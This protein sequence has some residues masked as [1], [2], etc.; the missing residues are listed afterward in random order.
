M[1]AMCCINTTNNIEN[2]WKNINL[3]NITFDSYQKIVVENQRDWLVSGESLRTVDVK[4]CNG[5]YA[6]LDIS[7]LS[8][9]QRILY[10]YKLN[11]YINDLPD[12]LT[13]FTSLAFF[14]KLSSE[15]FLNRDT[16]ESS[17]VLDMYKNELTYVLYNSKGEGNQ[18][19]LHEKIFSILIKMAIK[20][21]DH[22]DVTKCF[23]DFVTEFPL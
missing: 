15:Y 12:K 4:N 17:N 9:K 8:E 2:F 14:T 13:F 10:F 6:L 7:E 23:I 18:I 21:S 16:K 22:D 1:G 3:R 19:I 11:E 5:L 20:K